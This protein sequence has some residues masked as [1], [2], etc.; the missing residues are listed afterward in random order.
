MT[1]S[2]HQKLEQDF[3]GYGDEARLMSR[4]SLYFSKLV[5]DYMAACREVETVLQMR[6]APDEDRLHQAHKQRLVL[7]D[8]LSLRMREA[9]NHKTPVVDAAPSAISLAS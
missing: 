4:A 3:P 5:D 7:K 8:E 1:A 2:M 9:R 6:P